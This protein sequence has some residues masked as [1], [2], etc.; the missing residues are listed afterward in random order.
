MSYEFDKE[1]ATKAEDCDMDSP[2]RN[3]LLYIWSTVSTFNGLA[4][5]QY[6]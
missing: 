6:Q 1:E 2:L 5:A 3:S 4:E